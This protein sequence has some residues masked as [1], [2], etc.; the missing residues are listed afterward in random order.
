MES[1]YLNIFRRSYVH[2]IDA[3]TFAAVYMWT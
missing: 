2:E 3:A 1:T